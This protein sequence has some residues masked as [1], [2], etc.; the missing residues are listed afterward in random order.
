MYV[1][2]KFENPLWPNFYLSHGWALNIIIRVTSRTYMYMYMYN[3]VHSVYVHIH[4][5]VQC[6]Y[7][8]STVYMCVFGQIPE[9]HLRQE[10]SQ[11]IDSYCKSA[12]DLDC[13]GT[14]VRIEIHV[15]CTCIYM[16]IYMCTHTCTC[17][18]HA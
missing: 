8:T 7:V 5:H 6:M 16:Y 11:L 14:Q 4:V 3:Y 9:R 12:L 1:E 13:Q 2:M 18:V 15:H 10:H 17:I